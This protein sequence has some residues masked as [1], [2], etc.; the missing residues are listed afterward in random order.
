MQGRPLVLVLVLV[1]VLALALVLV[2]VLVL[3]LEL[4]LALVLVLA[5]AA[6]L[7]LPLLLP[8]HRAAPPAS[9]RPWRARTR[10]YCQASGHSTATARL[11]RQARPRLRGRVHAHAPLPAASLQACGPRISRRRRWRRARA[12]TRNA[13]GRACS[14]SLP[15]LVVCSPGRSPA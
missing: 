3:V 4:V 9:T 6:V 15:R 7:P 12:G 13:A 14:T 11:D 1:L 8:L 5:V 10:L 2:L